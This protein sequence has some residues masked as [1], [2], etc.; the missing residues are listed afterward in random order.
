MIYTVTRNR[1]LFSPDNYQVVSFEEAM[2]VLEPLQYVQ[3]D[4]E[5]QGLDCHTKGLLTLQLGCTKDQVV[6]DWTTLLPKEKMALKDYLESDRTFILH[7]AQFDLTF[8]YVAG[9]YPKHIYDTMIAEQLIYLGYPRALTPE[10]YGKTELDFYEPIFND[11]GVITSYELSYSLKAT[12]KRRRGIDIDKSVRGK[13]INEGL[14]EQVIVYAANDVRFLE[15]IRDKQL[16]ELEKQNLLKAC[17]FECESIKFI[18]YGKYCGTHLDAE[19]WKKKMT[20]D[21]AKLNAA[22]EELNK[23]VVDWDRENPHSGWDI[24]YPEMDYLYENE[25]KDEILRLLKDKYIR[26]PKDDLEGPNGTKIQAYKKR[27]D[28]KFTKVDKQGDLFFGYSAEPKCIIKW[29]SSKQVIPLFE[30]LGINCDTFDKKT[31]K[32]K[33]SIEEKQISPQKDKFPIIPI[34]LKY[35]A[36]AKVVSTY[37]ENWLKAINPKTGRIHVEIHSIG[38]DTGRLSSGG[39]PYK[40]NQ[41]N[42]PSDPITRACFTAEKGN[43]WYSC[44]YSGQESAIIASVSKDKAMIDELTTGS[45]DIH[46]LVAYMSYPHLIPRST[47]IAEIKKLY[48][49]LRQEAKAIEFSVNYGGDYNTIAA[50][51][52]IPIEEA[53]KIYEDFMKG[54]PGVKKYQ[55]YCRKAVMQNGYI[56]MNPILGHRAHIFDFNWMKKMQEKFKEEGFWEYYREMKRDAPGC[57][58]VQEVKQYFK[59]KSS[60]EKQ[61]INYRKLYAAYYSNIVWK[62][63]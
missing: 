34:F 5:T 13:I 18:A 26:S 31:K 7:N 55:D 8:L 37:G 62:K 4:T 15:E 41:Q 6:F 20:S 32:K 50:N 38:T 48:H 24:K 47:K 11:K 30:E 60:S 61:S 16:E 1:N 49:S 53:K 12:A 54:F 63:G 23:W 21:Q 42:L 52:G 9:I 2:K 58:T 22:L 28:N 59:R 40:L 43:L 17:E 10:V 51:K 29:S 27:I 36:A 39:G 56:L 19:K 35:Q 14:T 25:I 57:E 3:A 44:D 46:S 33:K 45:K